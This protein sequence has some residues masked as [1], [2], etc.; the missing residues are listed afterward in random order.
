MNDK[1][2]AV[3]ENDTPVTQS[4]IDEWCAAYE[5]GALPEGYKFDEPPAFGRSPLLAFAPMRLQGSIL[6]RCSIS[7]RRRQ[8]AGSLCWN[9]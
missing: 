7:A 6:A 1:A 4:M 2:V 5:S 8:G 9:R 3:A